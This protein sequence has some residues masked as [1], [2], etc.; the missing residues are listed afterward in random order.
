MSAS[1]AVVVV[2]AAAVDVVDIGPHASHVFI[3][4]R[5]SRLDSFSCK[6]PGQPAVDLPG[7]RGGIIQSGPGSLIQLSTLAPTRREEVTSL[8]ISHNLKCALSQ[9][10]TEHRNAS[11]WR[12]EQCFQTR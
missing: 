11:Q 6:Y 2:V 3:E 12:C 8:V 5:S 1:P 7:G 9:S 4:T 10:V